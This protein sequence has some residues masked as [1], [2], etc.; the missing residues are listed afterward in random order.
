[1]HTTVAEM[2][3]N[4]DAA[5]KIQFAKQQS[6]KAKLKGTKKKISDER[7]ISAIFS[8]NSSNFER[9]DAENLTAD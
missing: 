1:M 4:Q 6:S 9:S 8:L 5:A 2:C 7:K 3:K